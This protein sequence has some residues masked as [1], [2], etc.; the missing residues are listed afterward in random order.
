MKQTI[1]VD[2]S[3]KQSV[4]AWRQARQ[5]QETEKQVERFLL[6]WLLFLIVMYGSA[7]LYA[8]AQLSN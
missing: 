5:E 4:K 6:F 2:F 7:V 8:I 1:N 3:N